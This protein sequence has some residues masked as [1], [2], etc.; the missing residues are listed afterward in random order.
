MH[1]AYPFMHCTVPPP[2]RCGFTS[3]V[4]GE[5]E[6]GVGGRVNLEVDGLDKQW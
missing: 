1:S 6:Q 2:E 3:W 5:T 4:L